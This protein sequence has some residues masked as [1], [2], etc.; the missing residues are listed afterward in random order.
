MQ[1]TTEVVSEATARKVLE[2]VNAGLVSG[3]G[4]PVPGKM[5]V[6]AAVCYAMG[7]PH[8]DN[9]SC[10]GRAVRAF[11]IRLNDSCWSSNQARAN[12]MRKLAIA[13]LGS[14]AIDQQ[15]FAKI[16][17][18]QCIRQILPIALR[19]AASI[20]PKL[21]AELEAVAVRCEQEGTREASQAAR[22]VAR[23]A[24]AY[25]DAAAYAAA[26]ADAAADAAAYAAAA[27]DAA[28]DAAAYAAAAAAAA[29]AADAYAAADAA[30]DA[31]AAT[32]AYAAAAADAARDKVLNRV[33]EIGLQAL[34]GL[35][36]P[37]CQFLHL[38]EE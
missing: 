10:V 26:A 35:Q 36:S 31:D 15:A 3:L 11:K 29:A 38:V 2:V 28:A 32:D 21:A 18:E 4:E 1:F 22:K 8:S 7:L 30:A 23:A 25:A 27:A 33:S 20:N 17:S 24:A 12:G 9:P 13:Q 14:D 34:I 5:C 37:G 16:V 6:E 19:A